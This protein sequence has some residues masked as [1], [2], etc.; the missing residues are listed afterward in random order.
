MIL[1]GISVQKS[2]GEWSWAVLIRIATDVL[3]GGGAKIA[4]RM[5]ALG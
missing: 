2:N 5:K 1:R 3:M 4:N